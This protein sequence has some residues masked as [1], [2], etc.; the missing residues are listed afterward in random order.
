MDHIKRC[1]LTHVSKAII[2]CVLC[3]CGDRGEH[4]GH[5]DCDE[6]CDLG[7]CGDSSDHCKYGKCVDHDE[8][9]ERRDH[10]DCDDRVYQMSANVICRNCGVTDFWYS[11]LNRVPVG[12][13]KPNKSTSPQPIKSHLSF[14][15]QV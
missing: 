9:G 15:L 3:D 6:C 5:D 8:C 14:I 2:I 4:G 11:L 13:G 7:E 10:G 12:S 1:I